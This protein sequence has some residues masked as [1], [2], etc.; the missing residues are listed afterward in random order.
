MIKRISIIFI[1]LTAAVLAQSSSTYTRIGLGDPVHTYSGRR[2]GMGQSGTSVADRDF[3]S[4]QNPASWS[5]LTRTR[6]ELGITYN[7]VNIQDNASSYYTA[8]TEFTGF[9]MGVP[10]STDY[11]VGIVAGILPYSNISYRVLE[12][13]ADYD[14]EY[15][16]RGGLS[17]VFIGSSYTLPFD[18]SVGASLDYYFGNLNYFSRV[19][20]GGTANLNSEYRVTYSPYSIG[21]TFGL[22]TPDISKLFGSGIIQDFRFGFAANIITKMNTDTLMISSSALYTDSIGAGVG[23]INV[24]ARISAGF[25][26]IL[27]TNYLFAFDLMHQSW[28]DYRFNGIKNANLR[29]SSKLSAG[30]EYRPTRQPGDSFLEQIILRGGLSYE[31]LPYI[32]SGIGVNEY[33]VSGGFSIPLTLDNTLDIGIQYAS[34]GSLE[35]GLMKED[36]IRLSVGISLGDIWFIRQEK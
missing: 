35:N 34:R 8:E 36:R 26:F 14:T 5:R 18:M 30:F 6:I 1:L 20:F 22:I 13:L 32:V 12:S 33:S 7:G 16:G 11:G 2:L 23:E 29:N 9:T 21:G 28:E 15:E 17:K 25:S 27:A 4:S 19:D 3:I 24:P 31:E 10:V